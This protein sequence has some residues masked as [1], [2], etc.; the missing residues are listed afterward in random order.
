MPKAYKRCLAKVR[1]KVRSPHAVCTAA[2][3][4]GIKTYR[5]RKARKKAT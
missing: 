1:G 5:K 4:G 3:A 2:D